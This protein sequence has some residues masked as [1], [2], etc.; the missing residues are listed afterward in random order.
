MSVSKSGPPVTRQLLLDYFARGAVPRER[1][2]VGMEVEKLGLDAR[3]GQP[4]PYDGPGPSVRKVLEFYRGRRGADPVFEGNH[5]IGLDGIKGSLS[6]EP[7][8]QVEWS[9]R[10]QLSTVQVQIDLEQHL[11]TLR[12]AGAALGIEW[13]ETAVDPVHAVSE[14][15]WVP[16]ARYTI[17]R[18]YLGRRGRLAHRMMTQTTS[19]QCAFDYENP[20][21]W[22][23]KFKAAALLSPVAL[24]LFGNSPDIDGRPSGY[25]SFRHMIWRETDPDRCGLPPVVFEPGFDMERWLDWV[26]D[27]PTLFCRRA[28][29]LVPAGGVPFRTLLA[30]S[31]CEAV[32]IEDWET[33]ASTIFTEVRS[34]TYIEIRT[35]DL[36]PDDRVFAVP[37]FWT[38]ILYEGQALDAALDLGSP[39]DDHERWNQA[40]LAAARDGLDA[41][42]PGLGRLRELARAA[43]TLSLGGL[44]RG[45]ACVDS[46]EPA[47]SLTA[48]AAI[49]GL[50]VEA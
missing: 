30:R 18:D 33:H 23:R 15:H 19:V 29:G 2:Q 5:L 6:L 50:E 24:A 37:A 42:L 10:P 11:A 4:L 22:K 17:M 8:G 41:D 49:H 7:G 39:F 1:W 38:G 34:Y 32:G 21:D 35:A 28:Q 25:R 46:G 44:R 40:M 47:R 14:M 20:A 12:E 9:S 43:L 16:K 45:A 3:T 31:G 26:L 27:V 48:L 36:Q 13:L